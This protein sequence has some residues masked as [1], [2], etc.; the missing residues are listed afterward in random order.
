MDRWIIQNQI[1]QNAQ[2][3]EI[4][5]KYAEIHLW[6]SLNASKAK[7][8]F[9]LVICIG[10]AL[11][12]YRHSKIYKPPLWCNNTTC[13]KEVHLRRRQR[14]SPSPSTRETEKVVDKLFMLFPIVWGR[15]GR[16][17]NHRCIYFRMVYETNINCF[18]LMACLG[19]WR[20]RMGV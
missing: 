3:T 20:I 6:W 10:W 7:L 4:A 13:S 15:C 2:P 14:L 12:S 16:H 8:W 19:W 18:L 5:K 11:Q 1:H 17:T 9:S